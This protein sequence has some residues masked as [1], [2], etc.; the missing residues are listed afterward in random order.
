MQT[1]IPNMGLLN[2]A[3]WVGPRVSIDDK[4]PKTTTRGSCSTYSAPGSLICINSVHL[5]NNLGGRFLLHCWSIYQRVKLRPSEVRQCAKVIEFVNDATEKRTWV[6]SCQSWFPNHHT[7]Q[8]PSPSPLR[9]SIPT[10]W[11]WPALQHREGLEQDL[12]PG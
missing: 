1:T 11:L 9:P 10:G 6:G 8:P 3:L 7:S 12:V 5:H 4:D 2:Q